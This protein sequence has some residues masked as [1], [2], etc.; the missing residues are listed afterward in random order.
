MALSILETVTGAITRGDTV[1]LTSWSPQANELL[2]LAVAQRNESISPTV[3]GNGLTWNLI[4]GLDNFAIESSPKF[5]YIGYELQRCLE[6]HLGT[7]YDN[8][9]SNLLVQSE[10][11]GLL[12][13]IRQVL[14]KTNS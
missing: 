14:W 11:N 7:G 9:L 8:E 13:K 3:S 6:Q 4:Q 10:L 1:T 5:T 12:I 2:F